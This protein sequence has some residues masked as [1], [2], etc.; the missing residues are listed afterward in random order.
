MLTMIIEAN[1]LRNVA[2]CDISGA[3]LHTDIDEETFVVVDGAL[4]EVLLQ[5][6]NKYAKYVHIT[7]TGKKHIFLRLNK[8]LYGTVKAA[9]LFWENLLNTLIK[10]GFTL[11]CMINALRTRS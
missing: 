8:A 11:K 10:Q 7:Q 5:A 2:I 4:V 3:F 6:N 9:R 1:K